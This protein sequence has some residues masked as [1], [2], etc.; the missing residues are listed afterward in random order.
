MKNNQL[1][2]GI[3]IAVIIA[4]AAF[5]GGM[6]YQ[7]KKSQTQFAQFGGQRGQRTGNGVNRMDFR[8]VN[9]EIIASD[10]KSITVKLQDGSSKI[11]LISDKT[12]IG[13]TDKASREDLKNGEKVV[14]FGTESSD[15]SIT[16]QNVQLNPQVRQIQTQR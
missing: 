10:D 6:K 13:K 5:F 15:G 16:A 3:V 1:I 9:G 11:V 7:Q 8:P 2:V 14:V 12:E 4:A